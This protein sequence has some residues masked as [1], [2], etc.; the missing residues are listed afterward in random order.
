VAFCARIRDLRGRPEPD[1]SNHCE[2]CDELIWREPQVR[3]R[4]LVCAECLPRTPPEW[5]AD[6]LA[7][8]T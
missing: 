7:N 8:Q 2:L 3:T 4:H 5:I 6:E 1:P